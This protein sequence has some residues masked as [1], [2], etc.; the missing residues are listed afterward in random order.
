[1]GC[2]E[3]WYLVF[4]LLFGVQVEVPDS[5]GFC[6]HFLLLNRQLRKKRGNLY[7]SSTCTFIWF[8]QFRVHKV[9]IIAWINIIGK[10]ERIKKNSK[11]TKLALFTIFGPNGMRRTETDFPQESF[12]PNYCNRI[13][14][15]CKIIE[16]ITMINIENCS[17]IA[18]YLSLCRWNQ[19]RKKGCLLTFISIEECAKWQ[20][21]RKKNCLKNCI[22]TLIYS[23][24]TSDSDSKYRI[25]TLIVFFF[26]LLKLKCRI[27]EI[28]VPPNQIFSMKPI[29]R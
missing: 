7:Y 12:W 16:R 17:S 4:I 20:Q 29:K 10:N 19:H 2:I 9:N 21:Q 6:F 25:A 14:F 5:F 13:L 22:P 18:L 26:L 15:Q 24:E 11:F 28:V 8:H 1:M 23:T 3:Y 27:T